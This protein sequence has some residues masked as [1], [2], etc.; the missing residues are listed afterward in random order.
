MVSSRLDSKQSTFDGVCW[1]KRIVVE[2]SLYL[3]N[4]VINRVPHHRFRLFYYRHFLN[5]EIGRGSF[6]FMETC[7]DA[8]HRF[9][10]GDNSVINQKCRIDTRGGVSIGKNVSISAEVCILTADHDL[11][12]AN[13]SGREHP[14]AIEDYVFVGTRAMILPGVTLGKG[15]AVAAGAIVTRSVPPFTIVAGIPA[16]PIGT[17]STTLD[18]TIYYDRLFA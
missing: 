16:K 8:R 10:M 5:F 17:R 7:F 13:F 3:A 11:Q 15:C 6:V 14:V 4:C 18:Y 1:A 12:C 9:V 2:S